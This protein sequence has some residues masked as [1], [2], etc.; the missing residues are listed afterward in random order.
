MDPA[1][2]IAEF[3]TS[4]RAKVTPEQVGLPSYGARRVHGPA[5]RGGRVAGRRQRRVL[6]APGARQRQRRLRAACSRRSP[7]R[8]SSTTPSA[9]TSSTSRAPPAPSRPSARRPAKQRV[10]P[11]VQRIVDAMTAPAIVR[12]SRVRLPGRQRARPRAVRA[13]VRQPRAA[14]QQRP[15][16]LPGPG[17]AATS[18]PTGSAL[19]KDLVA[20]LRSAG[21]PQPLRPQ[22]VRTSIGEL[23]TRSDEFRVRWAAHNVR[24]HQTGTK[25][26]HHPV[27]GELELSY[28]TLDA[29]R[30]RRP[31]A[32]ALYTAEPGIG[33]PAGAGPAGQLDRDARP[34]ES[35]CA[36]RPRA[37]AP[38]R[39]TRRRPHPTTRGPQDDDPCNDPCP[40][41][42][43]RRHD[44]RPRPRRLPE[45]ARGDHRRRRGRAARRLPATSTPPPPTATSARSAR[46]C[47]PPASTA[48]RCS[49]RPRSGSPT[50]AT[51]RRCTG[52]RRAR[53]SSASSRSTC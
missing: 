10:R 9:R 33:L 46:R 38:G 49:S 15:L 50:T 47:A 11:V 6:P 18:T 48:P 14:R 44:A 27:V 43:Q 29:R 16:H 51:T 41:A 37:L 39:R 32:S 28:E 42:Q 4:R 21:R 7:A 19:A 3:L 34:T 30:R 1:K 20:H 2:D 36:A 25:R 8:C 35:A 12:N 52:S 13:G 5:P 53:A 24:F 22:P 45:P 40:D 17:R 31:D 26:L 23:S